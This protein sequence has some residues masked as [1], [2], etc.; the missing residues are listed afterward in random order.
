[1]KII[2]IILIPRFILSTNQEFKMIYKFCLVSKPV[3][4]LHIDEECPEEVPDCDLQDRVGTENVL[5][6]GIQTIRRIKV[7]RIQLD[8]DPS[9]KNRWPK[10]WQRL[11]KIFQKLKKLGSRKNLFVNTVGFRTKK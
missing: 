6:L 4:L 10:K 1:M 11:L 8:P 7:L 9:L 5:L 2:C 3:F